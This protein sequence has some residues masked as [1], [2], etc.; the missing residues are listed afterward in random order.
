MPASQSP[1]QTAESELVLLEGPCIW[2]L[3]TKK[4]N[5]SSTH[6]YT[7][8]QAYSYLIPTH[9]MEPP[10]STHNHKQQQ[11]QGKLARPTL[12]QPIPS[13]TSSCISRL[14]T[15]ASLPPHFPLL[16]PL[17]TLL[18]E[19]PG[20]RKKNNFLLMQPLLHPPPPSFPLWSH[21][22]GQI[23]WGCMIS[24]KLWTTWTDLHLRSRHWW[25]QI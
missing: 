3:L 8:A 2:A 19:S 12:L 1:V 18:M 16:P 23:A 9:L 21:T 10:L 24:P 6:K 15:T 20:H 17:S 4:I 11:K 13:P 7:Q 22:S 5:T 25:H 14:W